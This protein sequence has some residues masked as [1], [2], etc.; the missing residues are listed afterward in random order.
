MMLRVQTIL[1]ESG[2]CLDIIYKCRVKERFI[3]DASHS[4]LTHLLI[5]ELAHFADKLILI[6]GRDFLAVDDT[7]TAQE[8]TDILFKKDMDRR[9]LVG[10]GCH[11]HALDRWTIAIAFVIAGNDK[12]AHATLLMAD[13]IGNIDQPYLPNL[14]L[15]TRI[16]TDKTSVFNHS[17][18]LHPV[19]LLY[20]YYNTTSRGK[21]RG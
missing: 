14:R 3:S 13:G 12:R 2:R 6:Q 8:G 1:L 5:R 17:Y 9:L 16:I 20:L 10:L 11:S 4:D 15:D 18:Y 7:V 19:F 21:S